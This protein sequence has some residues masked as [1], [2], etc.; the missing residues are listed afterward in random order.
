MQ[1]SAR[2]EENRRGKVKV[3]INIIYERNGCDNGMKDL[4]RKYGKVAAE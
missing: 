4:Y 3:Y 1:I 2:T